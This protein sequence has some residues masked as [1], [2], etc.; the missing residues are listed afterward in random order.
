MRQDWSEG[1][2]Q[3]NQYSHIYIDL[4]NIIQFAWDIE[5]IIA[6]DEAHNDDSFTGEN[7]SWAFKNSVKVTLIYQPHYVYRN[8]HMCR[9]R[10]TGPLHAPKLF[11]FNDTEWSQEWY[12][13]A[14][15]I[16]CVIAGDEAHNNNSFTGENVSWAFKN[17]VKVTFN[18]YLST[19]LSISKLTHVSSQDNRSS[20]L[21]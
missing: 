3:S 20:S 6:G 5:C 15:D 1:N 13:N 8:W 9:V 14:W 18:T 2:G 7:V 4:F 16:E 10:T 17:R 11:M 12:Y 19:Q 21:A